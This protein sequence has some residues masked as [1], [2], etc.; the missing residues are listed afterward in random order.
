MRVLPLFALLACHEPV[1]NED[2][3]T[4]D[5]DEDGYS[6]E[7]DCDDNDAEVNPGAAET[8]NDVDDD[9]DG[10]IDLDDPDAPYLWYTDA[11]GDGY[12]NDT[13][14][15]CGAGEPDDSVRYGGDCDDTDDGVNPGADEVTGDGVDNDCDESTLD[16]GGSACSGSAPQLQSFT[17][18]EGTGSDDDG[19][20]IPI[21]LLTVEATD[22]DGDLHVVSIRAWWDDLVD[23]NVDTSAEAP[24]Q[25]DDYAVTD[26]VPCE[27]DDLTMTLALDFLSYGLDAG[28]TYEFAMQLIDAN[29]QASNIMVSS[30]VMP[31][32]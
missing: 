14:A 3:A 23:E 16:E 13:T 11:D 27:T 19:N 10:L 21:I 7:E 26:A 15:A 5:D 4:I 25:V 2:P 31:T 22:D 6:L 8:C 9:C 30:A 18:S 24:S 12:G 1:P 29:D 17:I 32:E 20:D 28:G